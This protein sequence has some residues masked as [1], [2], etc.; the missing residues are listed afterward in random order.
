MSPSHRLQRA[1]RRQVHARAT[2]ELMSI[3]PDDLGR[4]ARQSGGA[5]RVVAADVDADAQRGVAELAGALS[6]AGAGLSR[7]A[8]VHACAVG[9]ADRHRVVAAGGAGRVG[10][11]HRAEPSSG[12]I[13]VLAADFGAAP[14]AGRDGDARVRSALASHGLAVVACGAERAILRAE[15]APAARR[16]SPRL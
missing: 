8:V 7:D 9:P 6:V 3:G 10:A 15:L 14:I 2:E 12:T 13:V 1:G 16:R 5:A 11:A 4:L